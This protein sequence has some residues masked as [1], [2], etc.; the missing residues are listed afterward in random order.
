MKKN[1]LTKVCTSALMLIALVGCKAPS[2]VAYFQDM[3]EAQTAAVQAQQEIKVRPDDR[4]TII[5]KSR[6]Y[7]V[8]EELNLTTQAGRVGSGGTGGRSGGSG[9]M[10]FYTVDSAG[11]IEM[12]VLGTIHVAGM[13][14][15][16]I[17]AHVK[18]KLIENKIVLDPT[19]SVEYIDMTYSVLGEVKSPGMFNF[20]RDNLTILQA[21]SKAGD[22]TITG[23]RTRVSVLRQEGGQ[24][25]HY[26]V[27][28][29]DARSLYQSPV[30]YLQQDDIVYVE[31]NAKRMRESRPNGNTFNTAS[32]WISIVSMVASLT[33]IAVNL[34]KK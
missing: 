6:E 32:F 18:S 30:Y 29:T 34:A 10:S 17:A 21:I 3:Y 15:S 19:V 22:L 25:H 13:N 33:S 28:L 11:N 12:P 26:Y 14:R 7:L 16:E 5:V 8:A 23:E 27:D 24:Q 20:D 31:P 2:D 4:L 1:T 9:N